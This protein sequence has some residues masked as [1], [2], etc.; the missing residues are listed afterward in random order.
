MSSAV[1]FSAMA[2]SSSAA[3]LLSHAS[4]GCSGSAVFHQYAFQF[5][6]Q[7]CSKLP[8]PL[9]EVLRSRPSRRP[10][11]LEKSFRARLPARVRADDQIVRQKHTR[12]L[13][14][15]AFPEHEAR[16]EPRR[17]SFLQDPHPAR[18][19]ATLSTCKSSPNEQT[20]RDSIL[21]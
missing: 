15:P 16:R 19:K 7:F 2:A 5:S 21:C 10:A 9:G 20:V 1:T 14:P 8:T 17:R 3:S 4:A 12:N 13:P 11:Q 18:R 6:V